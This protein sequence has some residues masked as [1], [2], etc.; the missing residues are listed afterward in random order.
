LLACFGRVLVLTCC[1][2]VAGV[3][4]EVVA[5]REAIKSTVSMAE[6]ASKLEQRDAA[7]DQN[8][9]ELRAA[10]SRLTDEVSRQKDK[11]AQA[12]R[13]VM[14]EA[15]V[16]SDEYVLQISEAKALHQEEMAAEKEKYKNLVAEGT[17]MKEGL[18]RQVAALGQ[19]ERRT[20][21]YVQ[22]LDRRL[23]GEYLRF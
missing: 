2:L 8:T 3:A 10:V 9:K 20:L 12:I 1:D 16:M 6:L 14:E 23:V 17:K 11:T 7:H 15:K 18:D 13:A 4:E 22:Q 21:E 5:L 19:R